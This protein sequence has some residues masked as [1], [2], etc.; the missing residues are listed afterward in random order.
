MRK[1]LCISKASYVTFRED[2]YLFL[3]LKYL[4]VTIRIFITTFSKNKKNAL[5]LSLSKLQIKKFHD[6]ITCAI[7]RYLSICCIYDTQAN[8]GCCSLCMFVM[9]TACNFRGSPHQFINKC[10]RICMSSHLSHL[11]LV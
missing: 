8:F 11:N 6:E 3:F 10:K 2:N 5:S 9:Y 4:N 1:K 7:H